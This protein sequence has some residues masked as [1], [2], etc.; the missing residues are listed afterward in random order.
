MGEAF[1]DRDEGFH[2]H[3]SRQ[4]WKNKGTHTVHVEIPFEWGQT[5]GLVRTSTVSAY[6]TTLIRGW[7]CATLRVEGTC[8]S[9]STQ[10]SLIRIDV[11]CPMGALSLY[12]VFVLLTKSRF[13]FVVIDIGL[14]RVMCRF[15]VMGKILAIGNCVI[16][17]SDRCFIS[18]EN[19]TSL[20][21][22]QKKKFF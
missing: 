21:I 18:H 4:R 7:C 2:R 14:W 16:S 17:I 1:I 5:A 15:D 3:R 10:Q 13:L 12:Y 22:P 8:C 11:R 6:K 19:I 20:D 9:R